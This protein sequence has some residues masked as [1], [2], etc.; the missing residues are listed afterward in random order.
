MKIRKVHHPRLKTLA[1]AMS[2]GLG[3]L[4]QTPGTLTATGASGSL[5]RAQALYSTNNYSGCLDQLTLLQPVTA[6]QVETAAWLRAMSLYHLGM[7]EARQA[8]EDFVAQHPESPRAEE[9]RLCLANILFGQNYALAL[10]AYN[11]IN[12]NALSAQSIPSYNLHKAV[13]LLKL[14]DYDAAVPLLQS[15]QG[16]PLQGEGTFYQGYIAYVKGQYAE[17]LALLARCTSNQG[18]QAMAPYYL[19]QIYYAQG[20]YPQALATA[21]KMLES[22]PA[23]NQ[24]TAE[25]ARI[26][27]ESLYLT[28]DLQGAVPYLRRYADYAG[29]QALGSALY[30]LGLAEY[31]TGQYSQAIAHLRPVADEDS[32]MG[33]NANLYIGQCLLELGDNNGAI[34]AFDRALGMP[35][36]PQARE[37]AYYNY[38]VAKYMG[39][40]VP[41]GSSVETFETFLDLF[42]ASAYAP[43][44]REYIITGYLT[45]NNYEA[46]LQSINKT[47]NPSRTVLE[48]KQ[49][50]LYTLGARALE[51]GRIA[52]AIQHLE[53]ASAL[54]RYNPAVAAQTSLALGEAYLRDG[55][56][57]DAARALLQYLDTAPKGDSNRPVALYDL[58]YV[59]LRQK[60][61]HNAA[62]NFERLTEL[63]PA[64][65]EKA[66]MADAY[67]RLGDARYQQKLWSP[68][69]K[70]YRKARDTQP[71]TG[72][73]PLFQI[74]L[75]QGFEN[76]F[77]D[78][79]ATLQTLLT[80]YPQST[81]VADA[82]LEKAEAQVRQGHDVDAQNTLEQV[83]REYPMTAQGRQGMLQLALLLEGRGETDLATQTYRSLVQQYPSSDEAAQAVEIL[84]RQ[85]AAQ[86]TAEAL[87]AFL[88]SV[89]GAP[90]F[91]PSEADRL[92]FRAA[93]D[94]YL[95]HSDT[96]LLQAYIKQYPA[97]TGA[98]KA[99]LYLMDDAQDNN[100]PQ[101]YNW[102]VRI[103]N[104]F[105]DNAMVEDALDLIAL[106]D[107]EAGRA[108]QALEAWQ[109][110]AQKASTPEGALN[111]RLGIMRVN[112]DLNDAQAML[113]AAN[114]VLASSTA[115]AQQRN[116]ATFT[117]GLALQM[118]GQNTQAQQVWQ[119]LAPQTEDLYG[120]KA[121]VYLAQNLLDNG[122]TDRAHSVASDFIAAA[123]SHTYWL[124]RGFIVLS[125]IVR[126]QGKD[127]E[128]D[129]FLQALRKNYPGQEPDIFQMIDTRLQTPKK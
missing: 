72:D 104:Q 41:F 103:R 13:C 45:D 56:L 27:G 99:L 113:T 108:L 85:A 26:A 107:Y 24:Y 31:R 21:R 39:G 18:P 101:A 106:T 71:E 65:L 74:A 76:N 67:N 68:A 109:E 117:K 115:N 52:Q 44:V 1:I 87:T 25:A 54:A 36:D 30:I 77:A 84:K 75:I 89:E 125:D 3:A 11:G 8:L 57:D 48:A 86:G 122:Q 9:A 61:Y 120:A 10:K 121:A 110:L 16:T 19:C 58:G 95:D 92:S 46:A 83:A 127:Y 40:N 100:D 124:G 81:L 112:R 123:T 20:N 5:D 50:V 49:Q 80:T 98:L 111:A 29:P 22:N 66:A 79:E 82:L 119:T 6:R 128:A 35:H 90:E 37:N 102:A 114:A 42:P 4:A 94:R 73:Y 14:S 51:G 88:Q 47:P 118:L 17:A 126:A 7:A 78:K 96:S 32:S 70:A 12:P 64:P 129:A 97:G 60:D 59:R 33:Q 15:L 63:T 69:I 43:R 116:E 53:Q 28:G 93:E 34:I 62:L 91:D 23:T 2:L 55:R 105:P 38:A